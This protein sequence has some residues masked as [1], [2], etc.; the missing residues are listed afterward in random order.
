M[1]SAIVHVL[2]ENSNFIII[3]SCLVSGHMPEVRR[4]Y[5]MFSSSKYG[6]IKISITGL[7]KQN[8]SA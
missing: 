2:Q 6:Q 7:D 3:M 1:K 4:I 5:Y 8:F